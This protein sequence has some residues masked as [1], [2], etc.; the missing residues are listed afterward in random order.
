MSFTL[1]HKEGDKD[2]G[3]EEEETIEAEVGNGMP[4]EIEGAKKKL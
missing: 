1:E 2:R 4:K 3:E